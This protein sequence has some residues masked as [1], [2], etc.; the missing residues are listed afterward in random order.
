MDLLDLARP[1]WRER[2]EGNRKILEVRHCPRMQQPFALCLSV[3]P[4]YSRAAERSRPGP[5]RGCPGGIRID[6][7][8]AR[9]A[10]AVHEPD[11]VVPHFLPQRGS[12]R[13]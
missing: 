2:D 13:G 3:V 8:G 7:A 6:R 5:K 9:V 11:R 10:H 1:R 4:S 12:D